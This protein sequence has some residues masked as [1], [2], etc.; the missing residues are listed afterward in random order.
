MAQAPEQIVIEPKQLEV[1]EHV[2]LRLDRGDGVF[3]TA[4]FAFV[5]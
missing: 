5:K 1:A 4:D 3:G 2:R